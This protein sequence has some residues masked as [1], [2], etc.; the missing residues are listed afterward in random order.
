MREQ[1]YLDAKAD[2]P[3]NA[4]RNEIMALVA[5][6]A[7]LVDMIDTID[8]QV[9]QPRPR[10][11]AGG[12]SV[13]TADNLPSIETSVADVR[14]RIEAAISKAEGILNRL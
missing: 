2:A 1:G 12:S 11:A 6:S 10:P 7:H 3:K 8:M 5:R 4:L 9:F 14:N 13:T